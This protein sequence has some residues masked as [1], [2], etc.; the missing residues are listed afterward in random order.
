MGEGSRNP[1]SQNGFSTR[2]LSE[3]RK[4]GRQQSP[5]KSAPGGEVTLPAAQTTYCNIFLLQL[6][7]VAHHTS[8]T[9]YMLKAHMI[10]KQWRLNINKLRKKTEL[11]QTNA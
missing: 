5:T 4:P 10:I 1:C 3:K 6:Y 7:L 11:K 8:N 2:V 9:I